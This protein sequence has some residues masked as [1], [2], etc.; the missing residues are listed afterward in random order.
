[1]VARADFEQSDG[2]DGVAVR[3]TGRL[4]LARL[5]DVPARLDALLD[6]HPFV[7][8]ITVRDGQVEQRNFNDY[9]MLRMEGAARRIDVS[10][11]ESREPPNGLGEPGVPPLAPALANAIFAATG[12]RLRR[13]PLSPDLAPV[14]A[15][16]T[17]KAAS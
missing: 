4:T 2:A 13:T 9:E 15:A 17:R 10:F 6:T 1:M 11:I 8:L 14:L 3:F 16:T 12:V 7:T 5:G